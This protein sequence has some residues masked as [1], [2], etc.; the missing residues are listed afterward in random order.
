MLQWFV[1]G[2]IKI[3]AIICLFFFWLL[4]L[5]VLKFLSIGLAQSFNVCRMHDYLQTRST[6]ARSCDGAAP[7]PVLS[8]GHFYLLCQGSQF[9]IRGLKCWPAINQTQQQSKVKH[10]LHQMAAEEASELFFSLLK[11][12]SS[13]KKYLVLML[14]YKESL[15]SLERLIYFVFEMHI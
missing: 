10:E 4:F 5:Y 11:T 8:P 3:W 14:I 1:W 7:V 2:L 13:I 12:R 9:A 15:R 6:N